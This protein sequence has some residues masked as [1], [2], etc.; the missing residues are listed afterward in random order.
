MKHNRIVRIDTF[1]VDVPLSFKRSNSKGAILQSDAHD[2]RRGN[3]IVVRLLDDAGR[4]GFGQLRPTSNGETTDSMAATV[5]RYYAPA[6]IGANPLAL[7]ALFDR[8][9][10]VLPNNPNALAV[11]DMALHDLAGKILDIPL[12]TMLGGEAAEVALNWSVSLGPVDVMVAEARR[13]V[14]EYG[15]G[16]VSLKVGPA[17]NWRV[18]VEKILA[19]RAAI[20]DSVGIAIDANESYD[21]STGTTMLAALQQ[22]GG[23]VAYFEQPMNRSNL[24]ELAALRHR[25]GVTVVLD[26]SVITLADAL[27]AA[28]ANAGDG[29][30][31]KLSK[32]G[33]VTGCR[34]LIGITRAAGLAHTFGGNSQANLLEAACYAHLVAAFPTGDR[35]AAEFI[36]GLGIFD[37]DPIC[38]L[39]SG[40]ALQSGRVTPPNAPG[41]GIE[42]DMNELERRAV[43]RVTLQ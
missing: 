16:I 40:M 5:H 31:V 28:Q 4:S 24:A 22:A 18:D 33:G 38:R 20:G 29:F 37:A 34:R 14:R 1:I 43:E 30:V 3:P 7:D 11:L 17:R 39:V 21:L 13:A 23:S 2:P 27:R 26:E 15:V 6:L 12:Y 36:L 10:K 32:L 25:T 41:L 8:L 19:I 35:Y 42:V 9:N